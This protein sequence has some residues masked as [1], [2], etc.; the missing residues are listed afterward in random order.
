MLKIPVKLGKDT[1]VEALFEIR[2]NSDT[3]NLSKI[4]PGVLFQKFSDEF[5]LIEGLPASSVPDEIAN[6]EEALR[7][8]PFHVL[9]GKSF[10]MQIGNS[11]FSLACKKPYS[12]W[13][14]F[15]NKV[16]SIMEVLK[17]TNLITNIERFSIKYVNVI[18]SSPSV[19]LVPLKLLCEIDGV[20][21]VEEPMRLRTEIV[22]DGFVRVLE[23]ASPA[24]VVTESGE[25]T[26]GILVDVDIIS[27]EAFGDFWEE[28]PKK[29]EA[30][31]DFEKNTFFKILEKSTIESLEPSYE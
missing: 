3:K 2:F 24:S 12:G 26:E 14:E 31:H 20:S 28:F 16:I 30:A 25:R 19:G 9:K 27:N 18:P 13:A 10:S 23:I 7:Y 29:L 5:P 4:L 15:Y 11:M 22:V 17:S 21:T 1:I 6:K 8:V